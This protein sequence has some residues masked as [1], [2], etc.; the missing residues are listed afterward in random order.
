MGQALGHGILE[1]PLHKR[2][3]IPTLFGGQILHKRRWIPTLFGGHPHAQDPMH[4]GGW[5]AWVAAIGWDRDGAGATCGAVV[6]VRTCLAAS[7]PLPGQGDA[8]ARP[9]HA[10]VWRYVQAG[11]PGQAACALLGICSDPVNPHHTMRE[12]CTGCTGT[13]RSLTI[14][15][16][17]STESWNLTPTH[18]PHIAHT[19][20]HIAHCCTF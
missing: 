1:L 13:G 5:V 8:A 15:Q 7:P 2:R 19:C 12:G 10:Q 16:I 4:S 3:C 14:C 17:N 6:C 18:R 20:K 11:L 9:V